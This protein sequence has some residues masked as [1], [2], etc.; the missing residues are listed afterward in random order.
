LFT[1][2]DEDVL[3]NISSVDASPERINKLGRQ[4]LNLKKVVSGQHVLV[5]QLMLLVESCSN[6]NDH[7]QK[8]V[9]M[10]E[11]SEK[12]NIQGTDLINKVKQQQAWFMDNVINLSGYVQSV[13]SPTEYIITI[14]EHPY[15][16]GILQTTN[17]RFN[18]SGYFTLYVT[19]NGY[20][21][22]QLKE[23]Y[24]GFQQ[25]WPVYV[26]YTGENFSPGFNQ[27]KINEARDLIRISE[28]TIIQTKRIKETLVNKRDAYISH[29]N[30]L[31]KTK[32]L[33]DMKNI[34]LYNV[35]TSNVAND[36]K[37]V[38][39]KSSMVCCRSFGYR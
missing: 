24:G 21:S 31:L 14:N 27:D 8:C 37:K 36:D 29:I 32:Q 34:K 12:S 13:Y 18:S 11:T 35:S 17:S 6:V 30:T 2:F 25:D 26:E 22:V 20:R 5:N 7:I 3:N 23:E 15:Y 28:Q 16:K 4:V 1:K 39:S 19:K 9:S 33:L 10:I 38:I